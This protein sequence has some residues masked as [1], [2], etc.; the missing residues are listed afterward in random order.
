MVRACNALGGRNEQKSHEP[1][2]VAPG[3]WKREAA[4]VRAGLLTADPLEMAQDQRAG[5]QDHGHAA[6]GTGTLCTH[7]IQLPKSPGTLVHLQELL[8]LDIPGLKGDF[9]KCRLGSIISML[10]A[11]NPRS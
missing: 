9:N 11:S 4:G 6:L 8:A 7:L 10:P 3:Q 1:K 2:P 5:G